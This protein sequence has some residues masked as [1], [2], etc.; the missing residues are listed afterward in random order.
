M[1]R[2]PHSLSF[3]GI[4]KMIGLSQADLL[5][6][7]RALSSYQIDCLKHEDYENAKHVALLLHDMVHEVEG[8][9]NAN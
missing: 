9:K 3:L 1:F 7:V 2:G 8:K 5:L 4:G 6:L